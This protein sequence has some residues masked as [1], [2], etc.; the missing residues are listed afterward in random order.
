MIYLI[1]G[2]ATLIYGCFVLL[3]LWQWN[4]IPQPENQG[5][6]SVFASIIIPVR[7]ESKNIERLIHSIY[8][9]AGEQNQFEIIVVDDH[10][11]DE[12]KKIVKSL[13]VKYDNLNLAQLHDSQQGKKAA[14]SFGISLSKGEL[15]I[16]TDGDSEVGEDWFEEHKQAFSRGAKLAFGPVKLFNAKNT[17][18]IDL[19]NQELAALVAMGAAT[20]QMGKPTVINGCNYSF[21]KEA[22][23]EVGGFAGNEHIASGDDEFLLRKLFKAFPH[24]VQFIKS[25]KALV[26]SEPVESLTQF[27]H[28]RRRWASKWKFHKDAFSKLTAIFIFLIYSI[29]VWLI[30]DAVLTKNLLGAFILSIKLL[31]DYIYIITASR[32]Q[33][34]NPSVFNFCL[35][36]IIYPFYV[37]FFGVASNF[38]QYSWRERTH[39]I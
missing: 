39:K 11:E 15:M 14:I 5:A 17:R 18:W 6:T 29:W 19:L 37:V 23:E 30:I 9:S 4:N 25:E 27:Y 26:I 13:Q 3:L 34:L 36:Q 33:K 1:A 24:Q 12:T 31:I 21:A 20:L 16:C 28:Q 32:I 35:L 2:I 10:S 38:G 8:K 7:N 22:F